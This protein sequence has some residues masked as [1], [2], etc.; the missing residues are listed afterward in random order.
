M[1]LDKI[2]SVSENVPQPI[3]DQVMAYKDRLRAVLFQYLLL[4]RKEERATIC[5]AISKSGNADLAEM[6]RRL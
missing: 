4:A 5:H 1:A 6:I 2:I 3:R